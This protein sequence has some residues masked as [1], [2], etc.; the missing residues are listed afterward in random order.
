MCNIYKREIQVGGEKVQLVV[1]C[2]HIPSVLHSAQFRVYRFT[3]L[4]AAYESL[5]VTCY[6]MDCE[7][8]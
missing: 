4:V 1:R 3:R 2:E 8:I 5:P 7:I 6:I